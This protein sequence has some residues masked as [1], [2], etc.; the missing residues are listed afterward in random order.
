MSMTIHM[1][2]V[3]FATRVPRGHEREF[4]GLRAPSSHALRLSQ[5]VECGMRIAAPARDGENA[6]R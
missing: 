5:R 1:V 2:N 3:D 6:R 4:S